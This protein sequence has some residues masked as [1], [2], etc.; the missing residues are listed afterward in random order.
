MGR[1]GVV[2]PGRV[3][4]VGDPLS[5]TIVTHRAALQLTVTAG[6]NDLEHRLCRRCPSSPAALVALARLERTIPARAGPTQGGRE[7][8]RSRRDDPRA[9]GADVMT[10]YRSYGAAGRSPRVRG[11]PDLGSVQIVAH[12]TIPAGAGPTARPG[13]TRR[14]GRDD[15]RAC[16]A[17]AASLSFGI[18]P[19][20]RSP[21]VRGRLF[22]GH[23][24]LLT[25]RTIPA[26]A[27]PTSPR[28]RRRTGGRDDPRACGADALAP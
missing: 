15:P 13:G 14:P 19:C 6:D 4:V 2:T 5:R 3:L 8:G 10:A 9:C 12:G 22:V 11:R 23:G 28:T 20:G 26:R 27:G 21:R 17:D 25:P 16:G 24:D 7:A 1:A 18:Q